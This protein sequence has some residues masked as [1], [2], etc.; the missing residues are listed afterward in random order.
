MRLLLMLYLCLN[1]ALT[2]RG[3][4]ESAGIEQTLDGYFALIEEQ[5]VSEALDYLHPDLLS[6]VGKEMFEQQYNALFNAPG[7]E[8]SIG[9]F[10]KDKISAIYKHEDSQYAEV[11]YS[12]VMTFV[13][14]LSKD[15]DGLLA[16]TLLKTY[17][18]QFGKENVSSEAAGTYVIKAKRTMFAIQSPGFEGWK[19]IDY[20]KGLRMLLVKIIPENVF[21]HFNK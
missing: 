9:D 5:K 7:M 6:M 11:D 18:G 13:V 2:S 16:A 8:V 15:E 21:T 4:S 3:Q 14:D 1:C 20:E 12:F 17:Q 10:L 19:I